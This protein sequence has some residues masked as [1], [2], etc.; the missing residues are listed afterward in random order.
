M[1]KRR[2][3][4][5]AEL[6]DSAV[7]NITAE[8]YRNMVKV[9]EMRSL[10]PWEVRWWKKAEKIHQKI[11]FL[12]LHVGKIYIVQPHVTFKRLRIRVIAEFFSNDL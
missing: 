5:K 10:V 1:L 4:L 6:V 11:Y 2:L 7:N 3:E 9:H 12:K 8:I